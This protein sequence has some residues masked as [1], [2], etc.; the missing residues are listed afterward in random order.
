MGVRAGPSSPHGASRPVE[1]R[2]VRRKAVKTLPKIGVAL[3]L[4]TYTAPASR[5]MTAGAILEPT[6]YLETGSPQTYVVP[7]GTSQLAV[8]LA[9]AQG[10]LGGNGGTV[11]S[12][13]S[14]TPGETLVVYVGG[15]LGYN[16]GGARGEGDYNNGGQGGGATDIRRGAGG[17]TDRLVVAGGGGGGGEGRLD[18]QSLGGAGGTPAQPGQSVGP[19]GS[20]G[21]GTGTAGGAG[22]A[23]ACGGVAGGGGGLGAGGAGGST[24][25]PG[26][27]SSDVGG[28][29]GGGGYYG[30]GGG[31][32]SSC[33]VTLNAAGGG[34]GGSSFGPPGSVFETGVN[35]ADGWAVIVPITTSTN[36]I[37][38][39]GAPGTPTLD[40]PT[41][42]LHLAETD[43]QVFEVRAVDPYGNPYKATVTVHNASTGAVVATFDTAPS[44]S[45]TVAVGT[46]P[47]PLSPGAYWWS[48]HATDLL[49][50]T[51][52]ESSTSSFVVDPVPT[53]STAVHVLFSGSANAAVD[54]VGGSGGFAFATS[55]PLGCTD[56]GVIQG[57]PVAGA[58]TMWASGT[59]I[60]VVCGTGEAVGT[61]TLTDSATGASV[62]VGFQIVFAGF[63]G[64]VTPNPGPLTVPPPVV[65][66]APAPTPAGFVQITPNSLL[67]NGFCTLGFTVTGGLNVA[68]PVVTGVTNGV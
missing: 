21:A 68:T 1:G 30:G 11:Q 55:A 35:A 16:G 54:L 33:T 28:G 58:C 67:Q 9:G 3:L 39:H 25:T 56:T 15:G 43:P 2:D 37:T 40:Y 24:P 50:G 29:G 53:Y 6:L 8:T 57:V 14:V 60:N 42:G 59:F 45:G 26:D 65:V 23:G 31:G 13:L 44:P 46:P 48:A 38:S 12:V 51:S 66:G 22:G 61:A 64:I 62:T 27:F 4:V 36:D 63:S 49:G 7:S 20:G 17:L 34:G 19:A 41:A 5:V 32:G 52:A 18:I 10:L 47:V